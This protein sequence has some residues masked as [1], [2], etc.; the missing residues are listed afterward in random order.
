MPSPISSWSRW[1][2]LCGQ[3]LG[4]AAANARLL[5]PRKLVWRARLGAQG[6][7]AAARY[8]RDLGYVIISRNVRCTVGEADIVAQDPD[9]TTHVIVEVKSRGKAQ[10]QAPRSA[11]ARG[12]ESIT[13]AKAHTLRALAR[14]LSTANGWQRTRIDVVAIDFHPNHLELRHHVNAVPLATA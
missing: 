3:G 2:R 7:R 11:Q 1:L 5:L 4:R 13:A 9:G 10:G 6:E 12:E 14:K 8:L